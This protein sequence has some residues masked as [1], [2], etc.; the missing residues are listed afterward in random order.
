M[1]GVRILLGISRAPK[2]FR[3]NA[4]GGE[5]SYARSSRGQGLRD[6]AA[7]PDAAPRFSASRRADRRCAAGERRAEKYPARRR[8]SK[9]GRVSVGVEREP[10]PRE[11][12]LEIFDRHQALGGLSRRS[13]VEQRSTPRLRRRT[14]SVGHVRKLPLVRVLVDL[15]PDAGAA[16]T[17]PADRHRYDRLIG[18][19]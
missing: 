10:R 12:P 15:A 3:M 7:I 6:R 9:G 19:D 18:R 8:V 4:L 11:T 2:V 1:R 5:A 16:L 13:T 14:V 17:V